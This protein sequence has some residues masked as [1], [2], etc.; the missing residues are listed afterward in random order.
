MKESC[1]ELV[2]QLVWSFLSSRLLFAS[3]LTWIFFCD[4]SVWKHCSMYSFCRGLEDSLYLWL[5]WQWDS[6]LSRIYANERQHWL[7]LKCAMPLHDCFR[8]M[9][10]NITGKTGYANESTVPICYVCHFV[11]RSVNNNVLV[12][13]MIEKVLQGW[14]KEPWGKS[15]PYVCSYVCTALNWSERIWTQVQSLLFTLEV[16]LNLT[17]RNCGSTPC[18]LLQNVES[19]SFLTDLIAP[20]SGLRWI[21][22]AFMFSWNL[23][24]HSL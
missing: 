15:D 20:S 5:Q 6:Y 11:K 7:L 9:I 23:A 19:F 1:F 22:A 13:L 17:P 21:Q 14:L 10:V 16:V 12:L 18:Q 8:D 4:M 3:P 2:Q 24:V